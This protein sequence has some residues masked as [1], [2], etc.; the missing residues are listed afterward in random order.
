LFVK[1]QLNVAQTQ[2][3][4]KRNEKLTS[5]GMVGEC[6]FGETGFEMIGILAFQR[7]IIPGFKHFLQNAR[8]SGIK[9]WMISSDNYESVHSTAMRSE[10][11]KSNTSKLVLEGCDYN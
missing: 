4:L 3:F 10:L 6:V 8:D 2:Q 9:V 11:V 1:K 7:E 5:D